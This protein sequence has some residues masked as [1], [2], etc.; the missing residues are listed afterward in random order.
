[1]L[2]MLRMLFWMCIL[3]RL[4]RL[5]VCV[6]SFPS[7]VHLAIVQTDVVHSSSALVQRCRCRLGIWGMCCV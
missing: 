5:C 6:A 7:E 1:M 3:F 4:C 2:R